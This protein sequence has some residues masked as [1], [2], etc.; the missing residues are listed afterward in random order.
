MR[1][2]ADLVRFVAEAALEHCD[3]A[4]TRLQAERTFCQRLVGMSGTTLPRTALE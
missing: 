4:P 3:L 2:R 1:S